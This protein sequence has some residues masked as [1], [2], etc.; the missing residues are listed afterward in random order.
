MSCTFAHVPLRMFLLCIGRGYWL[1][2]AL[3][4]CFCIEFEVMCHLQCCKGTV[5]PAEHDSTWQEG[6]QRKGVHYRSAG[7]AKQR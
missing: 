2:A 5:R 1:P 6:R 7:L 4:I 3:T